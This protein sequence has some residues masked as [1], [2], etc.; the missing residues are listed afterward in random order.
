[1]K[2]EIQGLEELQ[3][4]LKRL[5]KTKN[6]VKDVVKKHG[7]QMLQKAMK[8]ARHTASGGVFAKGY[9]TGHTRRNLQQNGVKISDGGLTATVEST[10]NYAAYVEHGTR[11]MEAQPYMKPA[12]EKQKILF[13]EDIEKVVEKNL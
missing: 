4:D 10:T 7:S 12:Y 13:E 1:M 2:M 6:D 3:R 8:K 9:T 5:S 11:Y